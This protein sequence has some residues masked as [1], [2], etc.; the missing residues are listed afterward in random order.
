MAI[1][2][3]QLLAELLPALNEMF[4]LDYE[5]FTTTWAVYADYNHADMTW[6]IG[7]VEQWIQGIHDNLPNV[8]KITDATDEMDAYKKFM[9]R[10][11]RSS[12]S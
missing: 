8:H 2:R 9:E 11:N 1:S 6:K 10:L 3:A 7:K 4:G 5:G 12:L